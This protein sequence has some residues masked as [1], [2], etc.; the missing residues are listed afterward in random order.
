[1]NITK[2]TEVYEQLNT[3]NQLPE[4]YM[5]SAASLYRNIGKALNSLEVI[6]DAP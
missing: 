1:M 4:D 2:L 6:L 5:A 3:R